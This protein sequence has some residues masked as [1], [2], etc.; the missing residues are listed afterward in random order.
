MHT[1]Y[2]NVNTTNTCMTLRKKA[3]KQC[4][5]VEGLHWDETKQWQLCTA[6]HK[7]AP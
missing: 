7:G 2:C 4:V 6:K 3:H 5:H 1:V